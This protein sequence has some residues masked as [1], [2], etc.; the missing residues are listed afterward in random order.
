MMKML[1][2]TLLATLLAPLAASAEPAI[3]HDAELIADFSRK[4]GRFAEAETYPT[5]HE[6]AKQLEDL[7]TSHPLPETTRLPTTAPASPEDA[8]FV[9]GGVYDCGKCDEWHLAGGATAWALSPDG[10]MVTNH[11]VLENSRGKVLGVCDRRGNVYPIVEY[12]AADADADTALFRVEATDLK[13]LPIGPVPPVGAEIEVISHPYKKFYTHTYGRVSRYFKK[14]VAE[15]R[16]AVT[17]VSITADYAKGSSGGPL[18]DTAGRAVGM[19]SSTQSIMY[20]RKDGKGKGPQ[21]MVL[22]IS[23]PAQALYALIG[24]SPAPAR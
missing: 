17:R 5:G 19:V 7:T 2:P 3:I 22:K 12:L 16:P 18:L 10:L 21:Q 9:I 24:R 23:V 20:R 8:V 15:D 4:L 6:L 14:E 1:R 11:H 13:T